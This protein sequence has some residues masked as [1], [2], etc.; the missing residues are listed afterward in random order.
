MVLSTFWQGKRVLVTGHTGFKGSWL[1][2]W[3]SHLGAE[4]Y[5]FSLAPEENALFTQLGL[6]HRVHHRIGDIRVP[7]ALS[8]AVAETRP[9]VVFHL[10]A[11]PLVLESYENSHET[12]STNL[13][14]SVNLL[15]AL[16]GAIT[17]CA[18]VMVTTDKVY[19]NKN[20]HSLYR[21]DDRLGGHDPY[22][23]SKAAM[24]IMLQSY[25]ASFFG[26]KGHV[27]M[28]SARAGNVIGGG[29]FAEN[30][31]V[32]DIIRALQIGAPIA[33]RN[34]SALRPWQHVLE[35]LAGYMLLAENL[36]GDGHSAF[37]EAFN[38]GPEPRDRKTVQDLVETVLQHWP[39]QWIDDSQPGAAHEAALLSLEIEKARTVLGFEPRWSFAQAVERTATWYKSVHESGSALD[40]SLSDIQAYGALEPAQSKRDAPDLQMTKTNRWG[41][42]T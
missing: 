27:R 30:R 41:Q 37:E 14:G 23:A 25:R 33:V 15:E 28:A 24:E 36:S 40:A 4:V 22:S 20:W 42:H 7:E 1:S 32:P 13:M 5:G 35:P 18:V 31:I 21:E 16:R 6:E 34:P 9:D 26:Q 3:L 10:A 39:G 19:H 38:I 2:L 8:S 11:Q 12:W 29:D 17:P